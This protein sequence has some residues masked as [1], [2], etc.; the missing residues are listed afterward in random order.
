MGGFADRDLSRD[1]FLGGKVMLYQ[2]VRGYRAGV[3]PVL[4]AAAVPAKPGQ[5][6]LE[7]GC[8]AGPAFLCLSARVPGISCTGVELQAPYADLARRNVAENQADAEV[9][10]ADL[11][12]LPDGLR[13]RQFDHVLANPPYY[14]AGAHVA[15]DD[16]GRR[17][18]L[19][20]ET[21]LKDW[22]SIA[23]KRLK[24]KGY[25]TMIQRADRLPDMLDACAGRL[26]SLELLPLAPRSGRT[27]ELVILRA[28]KDGRAPFRLHA[29]QILH[30]ADRHVRDGDD[31]RPE[32]TAVL[33]Q[34]AGLP[35]PE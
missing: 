12:A 23:A 30:A 15:A 18:A 34:G 4:L 35:W 5:S 21:P 13:Q 20:E 28:R 1:A 7:L 17:T 19:G 10:E 16:A 22:V 27:A 29:P 6:V 3:D 25:L 9:I 33:K 32:I 2:P 11:S 24:P 8:G 26:G 31:Y 14:R